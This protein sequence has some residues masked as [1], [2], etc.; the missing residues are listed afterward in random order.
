[1]PRKISRKGLVRKL[2]KFFSLYIRQRNA[3]KD[4]HSIELKNIG[5]HNVYIC[6]LCLLNDKIQLWKNT[7]STANIKNH[8]KSKHKESIDITTV[9]GNINSPYFV[10]IFVPYGRTYI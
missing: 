6:L 4:I 1:M 8:R 7:T 10:N 3:L 2:D 5:K 9:S